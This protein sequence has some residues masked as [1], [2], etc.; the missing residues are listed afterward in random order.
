MAKTNWQMGDTVQPA[1]LN[2]IGQEINENTTDVQQVTNDLTRHL[3]EKASQTEYGHM[4]VGTGLNAT[5]G[6][7]NADVR[8]VAGKTGNILL[9]K[10]DVGLGNVDNLSA[11]SIRNDSARQL[12][13]EVVSSV[14]SQ[15]PTEA[16][17][18][19]ARDEKKLKVGDGSAWV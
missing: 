15:T 1:D 4:K 10:G 8:S 5:D 17:I 18:V 3:A 13:A 12:R 9:A 19:F 14:G 11:T 2:Q 7:V 16:R 6:V